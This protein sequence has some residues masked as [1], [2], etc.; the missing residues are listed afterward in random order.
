MRRRMIFLSLLFSSALLAAGRGGAAATP[1]EVDAAMGG[2]DSTNA[3]EVDAALAALVAGGSRL[4]RLQIR[5][6]TL[7]DLFLELTG[8]ELRE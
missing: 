2:L 1:G 7:E 8:R 5:P 4:A 6:R 3:G